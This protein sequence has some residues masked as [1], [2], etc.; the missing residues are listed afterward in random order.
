MPPNCAGRPADDPEARVTLEDVPP[1]K[2]AGTVLSGS[3]APLSPSERQ[4]RIWHE[5]DLALSPSERTRV[6]FVVADTPQEYEAIR[7]AKQA[8]GYSD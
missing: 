6:V 2:L 8:A 5:I 3:F 7:D 4:E 1:D